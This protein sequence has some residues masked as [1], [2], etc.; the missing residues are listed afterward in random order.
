MYMQFCRPEIDRQMSQLE[1]SQREVVRARR[2]LALLQRKRAKKEKK[3]RAQRKREKKGLT[4]T[5]AIAEAKNAKATADARANLREGERE[6]PVET[7]HDLAV[8]RLRHHLRN[9]V[10]KV[11]QRNLTTEREHESQ[12]LMQVAL[13]TQQMDWK[14]CNRFRGYFRGITIG[15]WHYFLDNC[16]P[17]PCPAPAEA[18]RPNTVD[19]CHPAPQP[20]LA[21]HHWWPFLVATP[22]HHSSPSLS[23]IHRAGAFCALARA[24]RAALCSHP[25]LGERECHHARPQHRCPLAVDAA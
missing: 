16:A 25:P 24:H 2:E 21:R 11:S 18:R 19:A 3:G 22:S 17:L 20:S 6:A 23:P 14:L 15:M 1:M 13:G 12:L 4:W 10:R 7:Q 5:V 9:H 8:K